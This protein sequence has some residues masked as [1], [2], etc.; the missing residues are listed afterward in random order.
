MKRTPKRKR[1]F[2]L[3][4]IST[5][6]QARK[7][8]SSSPRQ[9]IQY[10]TKSSPRLLPKSNSPRSIQ[11]NIEKTSPRFNIDNLCIQI[12]DEIS[13]G[14]VECIQK[15][16]TI[17]INLPNLHSEI[18]IK[19]NQTKFIIYNSHIYNIDNDQGISQEVQKLL[20]IQKRNYNDLKSTIRRDPSITKTNITLS[21]I[22]I[23]FD[24]FNLII[25]DDS[26]WFKQNE[27][28][29]NPDN[30]LSGDYKFKLLA[31]TIKFINQINLKIK[32]NNNSILV[33]NPNN[34]K[35][36]FTVSDCSNIIFLIYF[37]ITLGLSSKIIGNILLNI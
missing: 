15:D 16:K 27:Y 19:N 7:T 33:L 11:L 22:D 23:F 30:A 3:D 29:V 4:N 9:L 14:K 10:F 18:I 24:P 35:L 8:L 32:H 34:D 13:E 12:K 36:L 31:F 17:T 5:I 21:E 28:I 25:K 1:K 2:S 26:M 20:E 6:T 37:W